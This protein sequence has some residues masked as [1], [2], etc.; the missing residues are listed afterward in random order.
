MCFSPEVPRKENTTEQY[1]GEARTG[2]HEATSVQVSGATG[3]Y[4]TIKIIFLQTHRTILHRVF[5]NCCLY[6]V[7]SLWWLDFYITANYGIAL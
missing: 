2:G 7:S 1:E 6:C 3:M 4:A 5:V